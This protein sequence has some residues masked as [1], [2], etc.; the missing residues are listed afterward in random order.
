M[1]FVRV[2]FAIGLL[3][4][5]VALVVGAKKCHSM[6]SAASSHECGTAA[7]RPAHG[8]STSPGTPAGC[9]MEEAA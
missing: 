9:Q 2:S 6:M 4:T 7:T 1:K 3:G 8:C 5:A